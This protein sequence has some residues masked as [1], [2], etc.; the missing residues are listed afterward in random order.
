[1]MKRLAVFC[2]SNRGSSPTFADTAYSLGALLAENDIELVFGGSHVGL[3]GVVADAV[4][5]GGGSAIGV[6]PRFMQEKELAHTGLT[7]LHLV[8]TMHERKQ[9]MA[10]LAEGF[11]ALPGGLG[12]FEEIFEAMTWGQLHLHDHP[13]GLLNIAGYFNPLVEFL[14]GSVAGGF[15]RPAQFESLV[16]ADTPQDLLVR[17][18]SF[19]PDRS[20][21]WFPTDLI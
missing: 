3:M 7:T 16:V 14:R 20:E 19:Q 15:M 13:C 9:L 11:V 4:L 18:Q 12:T 17:F 2:G 1:M 21:K 8:D 6:L 5:A 10:E